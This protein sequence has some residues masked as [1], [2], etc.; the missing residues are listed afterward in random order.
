MIKDRIQNAEV[1]YPALSYSIIGAAMDVHNQVGPGWDEQ[2]YHRSM[3][4]VLR[5]K[6]H[7]V[8]S[9]D[10]KDLEHRGHVVDHFELDLLVDDLVILE[11]KHIKSN[12]HGENFTE[13][14]NYLKRWDKRLGMLIN[15]GLERLRYQRIP[16]SP[17][18]AKVNC[19]G[20]WDLVDTR[21]GRTVALAMNAVL[22]AH[23]LGYGANTYRKLLLAE[24][25]HN[26]VDATQPVLSPRFGSIG[27]GERSVDALMI[28]SDIMVSVSASSDD[29][30]ATDLAYLKTYMRRADIPCGILVNI[31]N[32]EIQLRGIQ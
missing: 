16:F 31:G 6:G 32:A 7:H 4:E 11:L 26:G 21:G 9:H 1:L 23:G 24:L 25:E 3:I 14:I 5:S 30:S 28:G 18:A 2:D 22:Q 15:Y 8:L 20:N 13:I 27:L 17:V 29:S 10:R 19:V 12:F